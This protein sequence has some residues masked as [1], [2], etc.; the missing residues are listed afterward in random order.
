MSFSGPLPA[1]SYPQLLVAMN[2]L[3]GALSNDGGEE[4]A[5]A[6]AFAASFLGFGAQKGLLLLVEEA[7]PLRL[8]ALHTQGGL[9]ADQVRA[10]ERGESVRGV[11][12]SVLRE[13]VAGGRPVLI[14]DPRLQADASRTPA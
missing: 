12:S 13:V 6:K 11:S 10:C 8:R 2:E 7:A 14:E 1:R 5:L 3:L 4:L 9:S